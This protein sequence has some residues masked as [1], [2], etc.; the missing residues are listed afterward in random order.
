MNR[1]KRDY[2]FIK[3]FDTVSVG[4]KEPVFKRETFHIQALVNHGD[5]T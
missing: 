2:N 5:H 1:L 4:S 3:R